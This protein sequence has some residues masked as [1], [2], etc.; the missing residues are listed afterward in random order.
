MF[1]FPIAFFDQAHMTRGHSVKL[2][3]DGRKFGL[4]RHALFTLYIGHLTVNCAAELER[5]LVADVEKGDLFAESAGGMPE[6]D[7]GEA[8][9]KSLN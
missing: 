3:T 5:L 1:G 2:H 8:G 4:N 7:L 6:R 9:S